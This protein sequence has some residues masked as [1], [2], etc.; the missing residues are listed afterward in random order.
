MGNIFT[1]NVHSSAN[2]SEELNK[3]RSHQTSFAGLNNVRASQSSLSSTST[4]SDTEYGRY[5][6]PAQCL[7]LPLI[8][9]CASIEDG[10]LRIS[11][12][13]KKRF[14][15]AQN[16]PKLNQDSIELVRGIIEKFKV[17]LPN[18]ND[19]KHGIELFVFYIGIIV[20]RLADPAFP[21]D[22][23]GYIRKCASDILHEYPKHPGLGMLIY[24][25]KHYFDHK[26]YCHNQRHF[27]SAIISL[28]AHKGEM[29]FT[30]YNGERYASMDNLRFYLRWN[31]DDKI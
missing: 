12:A 6:T 23:G 31:V 30:R 18:A 7:L 13:T 19:S 21:H 4:S 3:N 22:P 24:V 20:K 15:K 11:F 2:N 1:R 9:L 10:C 14:G 26:H 27:G 28:A 29:L 5:L 16:I 17:K 25:E 8:C